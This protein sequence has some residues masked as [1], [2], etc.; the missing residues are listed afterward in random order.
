MY[1]MDYHTFWEEGEQPYGIKPMNCTWVF[2]IKQESENKPLEYI[3][4]LCAQGFT[5]GKG[6]DYTS[7]FAPT[8]RLTSLQIIISYVLNE[9]FLF[10][11]IDISS[12]FSNAPLG[13]SV[14]LK[15]PGVEVKE[16]KVLCLK[17][18]IYGLKKAPQVWHRTLS[19][20]LFLIGFWR[21]N[22]EPCV[23]WRKATFL[24]IEYV[25]I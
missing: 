19:T 3:A 24:Y 8:R 21:C 12:A 25:K 5:E 22:A 6:V 13:E 16:N 7:T 2:K 14:Y 11:Q 1:N 10:H 23:F 17:K 15:A 4:R 9:Q 20:W 18:A